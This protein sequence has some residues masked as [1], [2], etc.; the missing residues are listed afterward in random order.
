MPWGLLST[1]WYVP[2]IASPASVSS[3]APPGTNQLKTAI[4]A[5]TP[6]RMTYVFGIW[7]FFFAGF[8]FV[9]SAMRRSDR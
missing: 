2:A 6:K 8:S 3:Y 5:M 4:K 9:D 1:T 7:N